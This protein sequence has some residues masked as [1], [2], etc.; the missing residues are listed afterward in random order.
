MG[1]RFQR[2][3]Q[4]CGEYLE[5]M[6][7]GCG[8]TRRAIFAPRRF[9]A[10]VVKGA[11]IHTGIWVGNEDLGPSFPSVVVLGTSSEWPWIRMMSGTGG[12]ATAYRHQVSIRTQKITGLRSRIHVNPRWRSWVGRTGLGLSVPNGVTE[13]ASRKWPEMAKQHIAGRP[14]QRVLDLRSGGD[15]SPHGNLGRTGGPR[16]DLSECG[17]LQSLEQMDKGLCRSGGT[18]SCTNSPPLHPEPARTIRWPV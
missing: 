7:E 11:S 2:S 14:P 15:I 1:P 8:S 4:G 17:R 9:M 16:S 13:K 18:A 12:E 3:E 5:Q 10:F 6:V